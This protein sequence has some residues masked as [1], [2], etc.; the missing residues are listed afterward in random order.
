MWTTSNVLLLVAQSSA[1]RIS[2]LVVRSRLSYL[3]TVLL[4]ALVIYSSL[5]VTNGTFVLF[6]GVDSTCMLLHLSR[7]AQQ[8][9][10]KRSINFENETR[11]WSFHT[12]LPKQKIMRYFK[13]ETYGSDMDMMYSYRLCCSHN[14]IHLDDAIYVYI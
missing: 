1:N 7:V 6:L 9:Y 5:K 4:L 2:L 10:S 11:T 3:L 14:H 12:S 13:S 8:K